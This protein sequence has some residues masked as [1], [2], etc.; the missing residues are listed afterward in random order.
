MIDLAGFALAVLI[1]EITPG[2][3]M[4]WLATLTI[5]EGRRA[6]V[7][8]V[9]GIA[10]GLAGNA[11]LSVL[12]AGV[13]LASDGA[14][15]RGVSL[16]AAAMMAWLAWEAWRDSGES[17]QAAA[18]RAATGRHALAGF[19]INL[20][21]PKSALFLI[22][23]M[24]Q[25]VSGGR[26]T[27]AEGLTLGAVSVTIATAIHLALVLGAG[28]ARGVLMAEASAGMVRRVL[29]LAMLGVAAWFLAKAFA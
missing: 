7:G 9:A 6:G 23:V 12:A 28:R 2:P 15:S 13:I 22:T 18:P 8:A 20:L 16:A 1:V 5:A 10:L 25:F 3:N 14:I 26:P 17:S 27:F 24:P 4:A 11:V 21:N 29:A 19:V